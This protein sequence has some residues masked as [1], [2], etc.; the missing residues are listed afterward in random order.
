MIDFVGFI[1]L[2]GGSYRYTRECQMIC[3]SLH[4]YSLYLLF[5]RTLQT[6]ILLLKALL[7]GSN[8]LGQYNPT[9]RNRFTDILEHVGIS[10]K[11]LFQHRHYFS[12][13]FNVEFVKGNTIWI[14]R[15][16]QCNMLCNCTIQN[17]LKNEAN[18]K[19]QNLLGWF[20]SPTPFK[21]LPPSI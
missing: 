17:V 11:L 14:H 8:I 1:S 6:V 18:N 5:F 15:W 20:S 2:M 7:N 19:F 21:I 4:Y 12:C 13:I 3:C 16:I 9:W 10:I